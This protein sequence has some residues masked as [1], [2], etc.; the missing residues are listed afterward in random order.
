MSSTQIVRRR[1]RP[2]Q[3][4]RQ[5][6]LEAGLTLLANR[7]AD[8]VTMTGLAK[9]MGVPTMSLYTH[10]RNREDLLAG[11]S[12]LIL[13][14]MPRSLP[15]GDWRSQVRVW[16]QRLIGLLTQYPQAVKL[17]SEQRRPSVAWMRAHLPLVRC[18]QQAGLS[19]SDLADA[20]RWLPHSIIG[21]IYLRVSRGEEATGVNE[22]KAIRELFDHMTPQECQDCESLLAGVEQDSDLGSFGIE[23]MLDALAMLL[24]KRNHIE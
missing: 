15:D 4:S 24:A 17:L 9:A 3:L 12:D 16:S 14:Q 21:A 6:V 7:P 13:A 5:Q 20:S 23:R 11:I 18:L 19:G 8:E 2:A 10:V 22:A 1:G